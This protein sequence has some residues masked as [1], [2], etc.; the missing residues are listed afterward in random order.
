MDKNELLKGKEVSVYFD[1]GS[2]ITRK[3]GIVIEIT[4]TTLI[5]KEHGQ[6]QII[7]FIRIIRVV[8]KNRSGGD[9]SR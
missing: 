8:E 4:E 5:F 9:F 6:I 3:D 2:A 1:D 7:P